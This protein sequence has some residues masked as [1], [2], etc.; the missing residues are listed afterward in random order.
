MKI[1]K[2]ALITAIL[3]I[4]AMFFLSAKLEPRESSIAELKNLRLGDFVKISGEVILIKKDKTSY[5]DIRDQSGEI[6][7]VAFDKI[8]LA[9]GDNIE[10]LGKLDEY[11]GFSEIIATR[12]TKISGD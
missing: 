2:L 1:A 12:V 11:R 7:V 8:N 5:F 6:R 9:K 10:V 4:I 3:G